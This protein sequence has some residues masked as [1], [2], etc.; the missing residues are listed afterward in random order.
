MDTHAL[1]MFC[2]AISMNKIL[3]DLDLRNNQITHTSALELAS[4]IE[5]NTSIENLG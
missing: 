5:I 1:P 2:E 4:A 3:K